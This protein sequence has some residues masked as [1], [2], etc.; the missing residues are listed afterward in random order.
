MSQKTDYVVAGPGAG[1]KLG[2]A[3]HLGVAVLTEDEWFDLVGEAR[4]ER[5]KGE[6]LLAVAVDRL[7]DVEQR[8]GLLGRD[9]LQRLARPG[10]GQ[11]DDLVAQPPHRAVVCRP[12][13]DRWSPR[14]P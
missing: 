13:R 5:A 6:Q 12:G 2:K 11:A 7:D 4:G 9:R 10:D 1:S 14:A 3:K 8:H